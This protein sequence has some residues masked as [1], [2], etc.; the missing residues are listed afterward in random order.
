MAAKVAA[1]SAR[2]TML[3]AWT[4]PEGVMRP[5]WTGNSMITRSLPTSKARIPKWPIKVPLNFSFSHWAN[6]FG[7]RSVGHL[8]MLLTTGD[9]LTGCSLADAIRI[10]QYPGRFY[11]VLA[12][13]VGV[14]KFL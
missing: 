3:P 10:P 5:G 14:S 13:K 12:F 11:P 8:F 4:W 2:E 1:V 7:D 6:A 9:I